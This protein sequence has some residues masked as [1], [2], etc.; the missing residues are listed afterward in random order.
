MMTVERA[1][2]ILQDHKERPW[3]LND[4]QGAIGVAL[5]IMNEYTQN[6]QAPEEYCVCHGGYHKYRLHERIRNCTVE[7]LKCEDCGDINFG[8]YRGEDDAYA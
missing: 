8:W 2:K 5:H 3:L 6:M 4:W 1:I 7:V